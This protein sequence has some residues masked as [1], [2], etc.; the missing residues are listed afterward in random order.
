MIPEASNPRFSARYLTTFRRMEL[1]Q[2]SL[3]VGPNEARKN[4][5]VRKWT[6]ASKPVLQMIYLQ[7]A[8]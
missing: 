6:D 1:Y 8:F 2:V 3:T 4:I 5:T 7:E